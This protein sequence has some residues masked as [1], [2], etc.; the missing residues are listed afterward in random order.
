MIYCKDNTLL[1]INNL[2]NLSKQSLVL[3]ARLSAHQS[4]RLLVRALAGL[5]GPGSAYGWQLKL[6]MSLPYGLVA[7]K[8]RRG[9]FKLCYDISLIFGY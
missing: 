4:F 9:Q 1:A 8:D 3:P 2:A 6:K 5:S 7:A